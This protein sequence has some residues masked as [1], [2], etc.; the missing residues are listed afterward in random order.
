MLSNVDVMVIMFL[1][2]VS[3][4]AKGKAAE[5]LAGADDTQDTEDS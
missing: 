4:W 2:S 1:Y 5:R 3:G